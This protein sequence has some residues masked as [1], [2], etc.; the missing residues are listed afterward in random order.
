MA[1]GETTWAFHANR[2]DNNPKYSVIENF[3]VDYNP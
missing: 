2:R 1:Q 3:T